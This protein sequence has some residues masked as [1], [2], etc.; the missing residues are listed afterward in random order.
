MNAEQTGLRVEEILTRLA[1]SADPAGKAAAEDLVRAL[2]DFYG[3]G[4]TRLAALLRDADT[5]RRAVLD[6][7]LVTGLL[8]LHDLHP[9]DV[10]TRI[11]RGLAAHPEHRA[12]LLDYDELA[13]SVRLRITAASGGCG[14]ANT[15]ADGAREAIEGVLGGYAPEI[16]HVEI[17][18][19]PAA[20]AQPA[21]LQIGVRGIDPARAAR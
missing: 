4:L 3:A 19:A 7:E 13:R 8:V 18:E 16:E 10:P 9:D 5:D 12:E 17:E 11:A 21:L 20:P 15:S 1:A 14:C 6:D 2:M